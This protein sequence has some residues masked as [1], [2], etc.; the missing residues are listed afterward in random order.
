[1]KDSIGDAK[2]LSDAF[3]PDAKFKGLANAIQG[4][5]GGFAALQGAQALFGGESKKLEETLV[6]VQGALALSQGLNS[7]LE[8]K[9]AFIALGTSAKAALSGIRTGI[10]A[11][12][13]G[14]LLVALG[15]IVAYWDDIK[16]AVG[17]VSGEQRKQAENAK[18]A[19]EAEQKKLSA[20]DEQ[21]NIL[22]LQGKSERDILNLKLKQYD[23][24]IAAAEAQILIDEGNRKREE[25]A[26]ERNYKLLKSALDF[27]SFPLNA[28]FKLFANVANNAIDLINKI[29]GVNIDFKINDKLVEEG[30]DYLTKAIFDPEETK[31]EGEKAQKEANDALTKLQNDRAGV[32]LQMQEMDKAAAEKAKQEIS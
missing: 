9:D 1:M 8:S 6:K 15:A 13:I 31:K 24:V 29:P 2:T 18:K 14:V 16:T 25:D 5:A 11:T 19:V 26:T 23:Q 17:G 10:A 22:R 12:G 4:A 7:V 30:A 32:V 21:S 3:N 20:I 28:L 27:V